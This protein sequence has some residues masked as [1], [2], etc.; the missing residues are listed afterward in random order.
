MKDVT[1]DETLRGAVSKQ[2]SGDIRMG[3]PGTFH[4]V[5]SI[6][7]LNSLYEDNPGNWNILVPGGEENNLVIPLVVASERGTAQTIN[8]DG[9]VGPQSST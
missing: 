8:C 3:Q 1:N 2:R 5:P 6:D 7:E 4:S 9:V